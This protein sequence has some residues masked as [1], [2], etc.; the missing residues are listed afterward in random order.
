[1]AKKSIAKK[2]RKRNR[3]KWVVTPQAPLCAL[4]EVLRIREVFQP[5]HDTVSIPQKT[6]VYRPTDKLVFVVLGMLSGAE[7]VSEIQSKVRP[8][9]GLLAAFGYSRCADASVIQQTL[10]ASTEA[11]VA[12]LEAALSEVRLKQGQGRDVSSVGQERVHVDIDVSPLPIGKHAEGSKKGY[13]AKR[14]NTYTRQLARWVCGDTQEIFSQELYAGDTRSDAVFKPMLGKLETVFRLDTVEKRGRVRLRF[15]AGF[16]TDANINYALWR[17]YPLIGKMYASRRI[18]KLVATVEEWVS[19]PT[20]K[21]IKGREAGWVKQPH[22]YARRT[23]QVAVRTPKKDG[24]WSYAV[25]VSTDT[26]AALGDLVLEYDRRSGAP[27]SSFSQDYQALSLRKYRKAGFIAQQ[28]LLLLAELAHNLMIWMKTWFTEAVETPENATE[29][30]QNAHRKTREMLQSRGLKR[31]RRDILAIPGKVCFNG[32]KVVGI[33]INPLYPMITH[34][35]TA[36]KALF[37][38]YEMLVLLDK[39]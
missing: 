18:Q 20:R 24:T 31:L 4:G 34:V 3:K 5:L 2:R 38:Q 35:S 33:R 15:D 36:C 12:S 25:L 29:P 30:T 28:V 8:D 16:G 32:E 9:R 19:V 6:V 23:V 17:G 1:M 27:E 11:T 13:I 7:T 14:Q 22:R 37:Q 10:D 21:G 26:T 39:T